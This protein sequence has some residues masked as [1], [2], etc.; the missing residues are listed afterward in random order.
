MQLPYLDPP[1][2][3]VYYFSTA[4]E[5]LIDLGHP[6]DPQGDSEVTISVNLGEYQFDLENVESFI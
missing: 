2:E 5:I 4:G 1:P 6:V 3:A